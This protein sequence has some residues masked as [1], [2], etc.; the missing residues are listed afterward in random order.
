MANRNLL[1]EAIADAKAVRET[2]I[3]NAKAALEE[4]FTPHLKDM[5]SEKIHEMEELDEKKEYMTKKEKAEGD[6]RTYDNKAEAETMKMRKIK[7]EEELDEELNLDELLAELEGLDENARTDAEEEGYL[8]GMKDEKKDLS[9]ESEAE[10]DD[11][12]KFE[13]EKGKEAGEDDDEVDLDDMSEEELK[14]MIEDVIEDMVS[15]GDLEAGGDAVEFVDDEEEIEIEDIDV[16]VDVEELDERKKEGYD[17]REDESISARKGKESTKDQSFKGRRDDSYGK[18]SK[19]DAEAS[20]KTAGPGTNKINKESLELQEAQ[21]VINHLRSEL[22]EINLLNSKL[23]YTNKVFKAKNLTEN[24]KIK[25][26]KA[27]DR[28]ETVKEAKS[29]YTTLNENLATK[30]VKSNIREAMGAASKPAGMAP[31]RPLTENII[32]EDAMV[33]RF[34]KLAGIN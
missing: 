2:A 12:D 27:F 13:Y 18:F 28:A 5:L 19:R 31:K 6:D 3:A 29:I 34:K 33:N 10:R 32:Q 7:E 26:L 17:D 25:V 9:E 20:G 23:L 30:N 16:S 15:S 11:V 21:A 1:E 8:D 4:A 14:A 24:Q 22:D